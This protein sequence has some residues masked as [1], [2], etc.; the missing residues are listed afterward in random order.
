MRFIHT[1][2]WHLGCLFYGKHLTDDQAYVLDQF[3]QL[4][5]DVK[6]DAVIVAGDVYD[7]AVPPPE[8]VSLLDETLYR[9]VGEIHVPVILIAGN[10][11]SPERTEYG[12]RLLTSNRLHVFGALSVKTRPIQL[13]DEHGPVLFYA[14][15]YADPQVFREHL[16]DASITDHNNALRAWINW[17]KTTYPAKARTV[18]ITH[19]FVVGGLASD[20]ERPLSVGGAGTVDAATFDGFD[21]VA[22]GHLHR[23]QTLLKGR[24]DYPGSLLKYSFS[25]ADHQ[26]SVNLV[27]MDEAG[28]CQIERI[29]LAPKHDVRVIKGYMKELLEGAP[30][31]GNR[32]DYIMAVVFDEGAI[33][34]PMEKLREAYPNILSIEKPSLLKAGNLQNVGKGR[35]G[36]TEETLFDDFYFAMTGEH[37]KP[38]E[39]TEFATVVNEL[40]RIEREELE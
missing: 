1:A 20:S 39:A 27:E 31:A 40:R 9:L 8:A 18:F 36:K 3:V 4:V 33:L 35:R 11:D 13:E 37:L 5:K 21:Y 15:P 12:A 14:V 26:K 32:D 22:L 34:D 17:A 38:G 28:K 30:K 7:R 24:I 2:D 25:E 29:S 23:P 19:A 10:H 16:T 6:P